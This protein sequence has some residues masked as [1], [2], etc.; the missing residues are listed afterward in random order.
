[1]L[2]EHTYLYVVSVRVYHNTGL[3]RVSIDYRPLYCLVTKSC[4][5]HI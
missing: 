2:H 3:D 1:V 5:S 4:N